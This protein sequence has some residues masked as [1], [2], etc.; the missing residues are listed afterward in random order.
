MAQKALAVLAALASA[1]LC[2]CSSPTLE[3]SAPSAG[4]NKGQVGGILSGG[5]VD[6]DQYADALKRSR[7]SVVKVEVE[8]CDGGG[9]GSGFVIRPHVVLTN[10][11]VVAD[12]RSARVRSDSG[13]WT[14]VSAIRT[15]PTHDLAL[16]TVRSERLPAPLELSDRD[17]RGGD[18]VSVLGHPL[19]GPF[20]AK[21]GR[22]IGVSPGA[23]GTPA[24]STLRIS[25][26]VRPGNS[27][28]PV[29]DVNGRVLGVV[30]AVDQYKSVGLAI[31]T[32]EVKAA[33]RANRW[34]NPEPDC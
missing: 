5:S 30:F 33:L 20:E 4:G 26:T 9:V 25:S 23:Q 1:A 3:P 34:K 28:G 8:T 19:G 21:D 6:Q 12:A 27:G 11:H 32:G 24:D 31:P 17:A 10:R 14:D 18:L 2:S 29:I 13:R 15:S 22:V 16:L 7:N